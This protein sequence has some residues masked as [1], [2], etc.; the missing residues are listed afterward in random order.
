M[1]MSG[2]VER[3]APQEQYAAKQKDYL[4]I[5]ETYSKRV[6][7]TLSAREELGLRGS[8]SVLVRLALGGGM[9]RS[10]RELESS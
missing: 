10:R 2:Q 8:F 7:Q 9:S 4:N 6:G 3:R 1:R 5:V